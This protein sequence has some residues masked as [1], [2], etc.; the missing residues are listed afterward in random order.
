MKNPDRFLVP[1]FKLTGYA[2][3]AIVD[4]RLAVGLLLIGVADWHQITKAL[5]NVVRMLSQ[6][7]QIDPT[8]TDKQW[9]TILTSIKNDRLG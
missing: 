8:I 6:P 3:L 2:L 4:W 7:L 9:E 5:N 1:A